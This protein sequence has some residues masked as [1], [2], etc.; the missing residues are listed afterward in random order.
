MESL[1]EDIAYTGAGVTI[2][3]ELEL[4]DMPI[5]LLLLIVLV[6]SEWGY[7]RIRGLS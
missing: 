5:L 2:V 1:P 4:W 6:G 7:R 3:E